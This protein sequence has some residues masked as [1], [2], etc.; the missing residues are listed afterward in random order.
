MNK[1]I[2]INLAGI[3]FHIDEDAYLKLQR[4]LDAVKSSF[5]NTSGA[6][7]I[8]A[9][10]EARI[11]ELFTERM[12]SDRQVISVREVEEVIAIMGQPEDYMV[13]EELFEEANTSGGR[14]TRSKKLYRDPDNSY[15]GGVS[16]GLGHYLGIDAIWLRILWVLL[17]LGSSGAFILIYLALWIFVPE[18]KTTAE[19]LA[20]RG[21]PV[22]ISNI[23]RKIKEGFDDVS[24][25]VKN[26][27]YEKYGYKAK[28]GAGSL[29]T[30][31]GDVVQVLLKVFVKLIGILILLIA[32]ITL[33]G[34]FIG[35]FTVGTFGLFD[36]P[37]GDYLEMTT[38]DSQFI[39]IVSLLT[40]FA[41]GIPF[42]FLFI[43]GLKILVS[44]LK[45]IGRTAK[46]VLLGLWIIS[47]LGLIFFGVKQATE[48][49]FDGDVVTTQILPIT[50]N[51]TLYLSMESNP[52]FQSYAYRRGSHDIKYDENGQKMLFSDD[53]RLIIRSTRD[54]VA[55]MEIL[56]AA[57]GRSYEDA[58]N[59]AQ[60]INYSSSFNGNELSLNSYLTTDTSN[61]LM[62]QK[63]QV[64]LFLPV[65]STLYASKETYSFHRNED[66]YNDIL[67]NGDEEKMLRITEDGTE[68]LDC[69]EDGNLED[70]WG[71]SED[72][73]TPWS[74]SKEE[75]AEDTTRFEANIDV[76]DQEVKVRFNKSA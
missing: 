47:V 56:K 5:A 11:A 67:K 61:K 38:V 3:F 8:N 58:R 54:S 34:L 1:T 30:A 64:T 4:Y 20:M 44:N 60:E 15:V 22:N 55:R 43:L 65:G 36:A 40:F 45:S 26:V 25:R 52:N 57:E 71:D 32:A 24:K 66:W 62:D 41:V 31:I 28:S 21:E 70:P 72:S 46:L 6:D 69:P 59:R 23:E 2:N 13:D 33:I 9:D 50:A 48:R 76:N 63:V 37:W 39:W 17:T 73:D 35:L 68:C 19:K 12:K 42:F 75:E 14:K 7:E 74:D 51:D 10:I 49:A 27:D 53:I 29:A 16:S 18:A